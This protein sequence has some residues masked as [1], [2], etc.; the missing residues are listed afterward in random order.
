MLT[1]LLVRDIVLI[2][3][4]ELSFR[5]GFCVLTGETGAGKSIILDALGLAI[6]GRA[7]RGLVRPEAE[8]GSVTASFEPPPDHVSWSMLAEQAIAQDGELVLRR[9]VG[10]DGRSRAFV[11]DEA[12]S[13]QFLRRL[14]ESL[15]EVHGQN[16]QRGLLNSTLHR[17]VLDAFA[18][19]GPLADKV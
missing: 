15:V 12:V 10:T 7:E 19:L 6:G 8:Q 4:L 13:T 11:N 18:M 3:R 5:E 2:R 9:I 14:G 17:D 1:S 16:D